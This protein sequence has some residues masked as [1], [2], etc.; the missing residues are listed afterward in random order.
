MQAQAKSRA[1][2][3]PPPPPLPEREP[4]QKRCQ[5]SDSA[6][7]LTFTPLSTNLGA[8]VEPTRFSADD[9][10]LMCAYLG[11]EQA[12]EQAAEQLRGANA[13]RAVTLHSIPEH[14]VVAS[15]NE[16]A[17]SLHRTPRCGPPAAGEAGSPALGDWMLV[18]QAGDVDQLP[19]TGCLR[20]IDAIASPRVRSAWS[21]RA[22]A[23]LFSPRF[24]ARAAAGCE[25]QL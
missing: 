23:G 10:Q 19:R 17:L 13:A 22:A 7:L 8:A 11:G 25:W 20:I 2:R 3:R 24:T 4:E 14:E 15:Q 6:P 18:G 21:P 9:M 5:G 16:G 12:A 1:A